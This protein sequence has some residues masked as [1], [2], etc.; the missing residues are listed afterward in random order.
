MPEKIRNEI[1]PPASGS[2]SLVLKSKTYNKIRGFIETANRTT[3]SRQPGTNNKWP[4][5]N[6]TVIQ[7]GNRGDLIQA[8]TPVRVLSLNNN[9]DINNDRLLIPY[10]QDRKFQASTTLNNEQPIIGVTLDA[11]PPNGWGQVVVLGVVCVRCEILYQNDPAD[12]WLKVNDTEDGLI[13]TFEET[14]IKVIEAYREGTDQYAKVLIGAGGGGTGVAIPLDLLKVGGMQGTGTSKPSWTYNVFDA[15][16]RPNTDNPIYL[17][18]NPTIAPHHWVR[19]LGQMLPAT[20]GWGY[21]HP[22]GVEI[23]WINE[24][25]IAAECAPGGGPTP[26]AG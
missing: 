24:Q 19:H 14:S 13:Q 25:L 2:K 3:D 23:T 17:A 1:L 4:G 26:P 5:T 21:D 16:E 15:R 22:S 10:R 9:I 18:V 7:C 8:Y 20:F 11:I 6:S 12:T